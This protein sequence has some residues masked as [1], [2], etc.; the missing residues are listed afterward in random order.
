MSLERAGRMA[1]L[2][3]TATGI[4]YRKFWAERYKVSGA[5]T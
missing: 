5:I 2:W 3:G 4:V 1:A